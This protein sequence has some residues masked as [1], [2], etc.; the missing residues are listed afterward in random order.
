MENLKIIYV[1]QIRPGTSVFCS[2]ETCIDKARHTIF[3]ASNYNIVKQGIQPVFIGASTKQKPVS[4]DNL[5][6]HQYS[7]KEI[8]EK[9]EINYSWPSWRTCI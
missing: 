2:V 4:V 3:V 6:E 8:E 5:P 1:D 9:K 7:S